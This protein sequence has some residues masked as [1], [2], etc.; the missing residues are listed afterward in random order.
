MN[1]AIT[2]H[3]RNVAGQWKG[4][5]LH[6]YDPGYVFSPYITSS[7]VEKALEAT[8][9]SRIEV[10]TS[11]DIASFAAG[12]S[13]LS[14]LK[15]LHKIGYPLFHV[16]RLHAKI[17]FHPRKFAT[18]G[19]QNLTQRGTLNREATVVITDAGLM[20][21]MRK[22]IDRWMAD[23]RPISLEMIQ[24]AEVQIAT[25]V[26]EYRRL[27]RISKRLERQIFDAEDYRLSDA[28]RTELRQQEDL[29]AYR[30]QLRQ[31]LEQMGDGHSVSKEFCENVAYNAIEWRRQGRIVR[32][33][34]HAFR[35]RPGPHGRELPLGENR[36]ALELAIRLCRDEIEKMFPSDK[37]RLFTLTPD[38]V[39]RLCVFVTAAIIGHKNRLYSTSYPVDEDGRMWLGN[40]AVNSVN[41]VA[42]ILQFAGFEQSSG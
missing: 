31:K 16:P 34:R 20:A 4:A 24:E 6:C 42:A 15:S 19:S 22:Q 30:D 26:R 27:N 21:Q 23:R 17:V 41:T 2:I 38:E 39:T 35:I 32:S 29:C 28:A 9:P 7:L 37:T 3:C 40:H 10:H 11:F 1:A 33:R 25:L 13:S 8:L 5:F 18:V 36:F 14:S 12:A